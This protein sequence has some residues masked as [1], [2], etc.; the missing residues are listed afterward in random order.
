MR[1]VLLLAALILP[2]PASGGAWMR[3]VGTTFLSFGTTIYVN[4]ETQGTVFVE[5]GLRPKLTFGLKIDV[6]MNQGQTTGGTF[7]VFLLKPIPTGTRPY[8]VAY[9][10]AVGSSFGGQSSALLRA[11]LS[12]GRGITVRE[13]SGW[14]SID[15]AAEWLARDDATTLKLDGTLGLTLTP[16]LQV[17]MQVFV[18][19]TST[20]TSTTLAPSAIW[21]PKPDAPTQYQFGLEAKDG[22]TAL[23]LG[24]WR[25]F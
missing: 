16:Q 3:E 18:S 7:Y 22:I 21:R 2:F 24:V 25:S 13:K 5:Y 6:N 20:D 11:G 17:M 12:Y 9:E 8:K 19:Q 15:T 23:K 4:D 1:L 10:M 14:L